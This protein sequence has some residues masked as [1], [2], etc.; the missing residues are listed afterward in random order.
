MIN[1]TITFA[2]AFL[3]SGSIPCFSQIDTT[4]R[5]FFPMNIGNYWEYMDEEIPTFIHY[6]VSVKGD[7][8]LSNGK[9]YQVFQTILLSPSPDTT[10]THY[11]MTDSLD[12][13]QYFSGSSSCAENEYLIHRLIFPDRHLWTVCLDWIPNSQD[14]LG[15]YL[16]QNEYLPYLALDTVT[17]L[18][19]SATI[20][21]SSGDTLW[22]SG[23]PY[24]YDKRLFAQG[25]GSVKAEG[26]AGA[27][28]Y[29]VGAIID[30]RV[31]GVVSNIRNELKYSFSGFE[32]FQNS[33]NPFNPV[34]TISF[35]IPME[36]HVRLAVFDM[37][38]RE[39]AVLENSIKTSGFYQRA[40][41]ASSLSSGIYL[42]RL[43]TPNFTAV[44][45]MVVAK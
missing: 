44:R 40:F 26:E 21:L 32:L 39:V 4:L 17:K 37:L 41:D 10:Y 33:P 20:E 5:S 30:G 1:R 29:L 16:T 18:V 7:T 14:Y 35:S 43:Q 28:V 42:Y 25:I 38:G 36:G 15:I 22:N 24:G 8:I 9:T 3:F 31:Y 6:S 23:I 12:V 11:R 27:P 19:M 2:F 34:T 45:K 13:Y